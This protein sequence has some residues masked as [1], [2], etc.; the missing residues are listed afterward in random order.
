MKKNVFIL[1]YLFLLCG[2][3]D[4]PLVDKVK[5][6]NIPS[7]KKT[8]LTIYHSS[9][10]EIKAQKTQQEW[11]KCLAYFKTKLNLD[12]GEVNLALLDETDF[13]K[14]SS[15][16]YPYGFPFVRGNPPVAFLPA[17]SQGIV[18]IETRK[19]LQLLD[20]ASV[21]QM[22]L[23]GFDQNTAVD[24]SVDLIGFHELGHLFSEKMNIQT[25][26]TDDELLWL[27]E[28]VA[29]YFAYCY[30]YENDLQA[31]KL[32]VLTSKSV[33]QSWTPE[34]VELKMMYKFR[35]DAK[36]YGW[37]QSKLIIMASEI[38]AKHQLALLEVLAKEGEQSKMAEKFVELTK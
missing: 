35:K 14:L 26:L 6:L 8:N 7:I 9:N 32:W 13:K 28:W 25:K 27:K 38:Y 3:S 34:T 24:K 12:I 23:Q 29:T 20:T 21:N 36:V 19:V 2:C 1:C 15:L 11:L 30:L 22:T 31:A 37:Y 10:C 16:P 33:V 17:A 5:L 18:A 4:K